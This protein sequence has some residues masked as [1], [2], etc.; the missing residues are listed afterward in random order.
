M[1]N[2]YFIYRY[3]SVLLAATMYANEVGAEMQQ[4]GI[5]RLVVNV[6]ID[7]LRSD[8]L[9]AFS[10]LYLEGGFNKLLKNGKVYVD[11]INSFA[12]AD[13]ASATAT[14][15]SGTTPYYNGVVAGS[16]LDRATLRPVSCTDDKKVV[17]TSGTAKASARRLLTSTIGD[18]LKRYTHGA[19]KVFGIAP[20]CDAA[21]LSAGHAA[22]GAVWID[23]NT[24]VW[25]TTDY[26]IQPKNHWITNYIRGHQLVNTVSSAKWIPMVNFSTSASFFVNQGTKNTFTH[27]FTGD[28]RFL[29][30]KRSA[31]VN[32]DIT[33]IALA[34][35]QTNNLGADD[36][37]DLL[38][39]QY[40]AG[41]FQDG[42]LSDSQLEL[43][44][45]YLRLDKEI[46]RLIEVLER[47]VG[48]GNVIFVFS[49][50]GYCLGDNSDYDKYN[51]PSGNFYINRTANLLNM[52]LSSIYGT[53]QY[54]DACYRNHIYLNHKL[55]E[56]KHISIADVSSRAVE[57][58]QMSDG[59]RDVHTTQS[60]LASSSGDVFL[61]RNAY[62]PTLLGDIV[63][64]VAPGWQLVNEDT[65]ETY[66]QLAS[67]VSF[68]IIFF[69]EGIKAE[70][71]TGFVSTDRIAPTITKII[72]IRAP[73]GCR[74]LPLF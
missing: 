23:D 5:P 20:D 67:T 68:P 52:F 44:D 32:A 36:I 13:R 16:W 19:S 2:S 21:I 34:C 73:N 71:I 42:N 17:A 45:T 37:T 9:E 65:G 58:L 24:G 47:R 74:S 14:I 28:R 7:Q 26:Y 11:G 29:E 54:V 50:T 51:I 39:I 60:I 41:A 31:L 15:S 10:S 35:Q 55:L 3:L 56:R 66:T 62:N 72:R 27:K 59:V 6:T 4:A 1:K 18:E 70:K 25:M 46:Q 61:L 57:F 38:S 63:I 48:K 33:E 69:G 40:Y 53:G 12:P 43:Q 22:D 64:E 30:Y 49:S 8:Y